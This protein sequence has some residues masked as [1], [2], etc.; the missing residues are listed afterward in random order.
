MGSC[1]KSA[2]D[3]LQA[4]VSF[5]PRFEDKLYLTALVL[6]HPFFHHYLSRTRVHDL[7]RKM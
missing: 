3:T 4:L 5:S 1:S 2:T 6:P 7:K